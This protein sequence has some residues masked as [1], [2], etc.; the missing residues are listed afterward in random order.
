MFF[1]WYGLASK[2]S[3]PSWHLGHLEVK[4][5]YN[6][7]PF[8]SMGSRLRFFRKNL[9]KVGRCLTGEC[10][11]CHPNAERTSS[12]SSLRR[13]GPF[14]RHFFSGQSWR[15]D[16]PRGPKWC[17]EIDLVEADCRALC[18]GHGQ[19]FYPKWVQDR[20]PHPGYSAQTQHHR[21][22]RPLPVLSRLKSSKPKSKG[23]TKRWRPAPITSPIAT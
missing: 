17:R 5:E 23:G 16:R 18:P 22:G 12:W 13:H 15:T 10:Y 8:P 2:K 11:F 9:V 14:Q 3:F 6:F 4:M 21:L 20:L 7:W 19:S 1:K